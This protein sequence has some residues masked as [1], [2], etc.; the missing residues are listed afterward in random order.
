T[1]PIPLPMRCPLRRRWHSDRAHRSNGLTTKVMVL[2]SAT[3]NDS[4]EEGKSMSDRRRRHAAGTGLSR[5]A[6]VRR[7]ALGGLGLAGA[8][9]IGCG[10]DEDGGTS[11][12]SG[13]A[14]PGS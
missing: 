2:A 3:Y 9:L 5:R 1:C 6:V 7:G 11:T 10:D 14:G 8:A 13:T 4:L 12:P